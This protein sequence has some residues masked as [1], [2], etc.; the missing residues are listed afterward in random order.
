VNPPPAPS[1]GG[2]SISPSGGGARRAGEEKPGNLMEKF[3]KSLSKKKI[4]ETEKSKPPLQHFAQKQ[5]K[6]ITI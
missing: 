4:V 1:S 5:C 6:D 2:Q 3:P